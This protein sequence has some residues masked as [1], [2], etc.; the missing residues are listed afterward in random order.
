MYTVERCSSGQWRTIRRDEMWSDRDPESFARGLLELWV[1]R[2]RRPPSGRVRVIGGRRGD[3]AGRDDLGG[4]AA[5]VRI[6]VY[7]NSLDRVAALPRQPVATAYLA[8]L[9]RGDFDT[10]A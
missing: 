4:D 6:R 3:K 9:V 8:P 7:L 2:Q 1:I 10:A 5:I